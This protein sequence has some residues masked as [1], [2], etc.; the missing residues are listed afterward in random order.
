VNPPIMLC[1]RKGAAK[2]STLSKRKM[3]F[4]KS[5]CAHCTWNASYQLVSDV[6]P[7]IALFRISVTR[8]SN[9]M[10]VAFLSYR[11]SILVTSFRVSNLS[12]TVARSYWPNIVKAQITL[13][14]SM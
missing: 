9:G 3:G 14:H 2:C 6:R 5:N 10:I 8:E 7:F 11:I 4:T 12:A 1:V 13:G